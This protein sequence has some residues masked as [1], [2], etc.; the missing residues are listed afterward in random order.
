MVNKTKIAELIYAIKCELDYIEEDLLFCSKKLPYSNR[1]RV[2]E[3]SVQINISE[4]G[5]KKYG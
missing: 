3:F 2:G 1:F 5:V 4:P